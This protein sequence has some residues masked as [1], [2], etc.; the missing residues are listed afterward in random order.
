MEI[1]FNFNSDNPA[2]SMLSD[3]ANFAEGGGLF[4]I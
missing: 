2:K 3:C 4:S 1:P